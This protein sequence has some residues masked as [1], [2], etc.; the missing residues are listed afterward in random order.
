M[1]TCN[2]TVYSSLRINKEHKRNVHVWIATYDKFFE[3]LPVKELFIFVSFNRNT[4]C[5][6]TSNPMN[7]GF[8]FLS[9]NYYMVHII[10]YNE[11]SAN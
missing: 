7:V 2:F 3:K 5:T 10:M 6:Y 8:G 9:L 4:L 11:I 1:Q